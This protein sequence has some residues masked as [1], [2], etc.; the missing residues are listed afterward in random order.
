MSDI[1]D[2]VKLYFAIRLIF[3][4]NSLTPA[5]FAQLQRAASAIHSSIYTVSIERRSSIQNFLE[6]HE[7]YQ[8]E[9]DDLEQQEKELQLL[10]YPRK[11][12]NEL[13]SGMEVEFRCV[14]IA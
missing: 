9:A 4:P 2:S 13:K 14:T 7:I 8:E 1:S 5:S 3:Y 6:I 12:E 11:A 10:P